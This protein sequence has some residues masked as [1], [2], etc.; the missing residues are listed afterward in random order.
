MDFDLRGNL[1]QSIELTFQEFKEQFVTNWAAEDTTRSSIFNV[2][3]T[4]IADFQALITPDFVT[5]VDGSFVSNKKSNPND[6]DFVSF[7][8]SKTYDDKTDLI[9][10]RFGKFGVKK[11]YGEDL[12]AYICP[13]YPENHQKAFYTKSDTLEWLHQ[14]SHTKPKKVGDKSFSKG[15]I[16]IKFQ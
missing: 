9:N 4:Y 10:K 3:E 7:I 6:I 12:D 1:T 11:F 13:V 16:T 8:N 2:F 14:F 15:F 5:W